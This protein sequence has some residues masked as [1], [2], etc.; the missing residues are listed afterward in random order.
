[1]RTHERPVSSLSTS[2]AAECREAMAKLLLLHLPQLLLL[3]LLLLSSL[4]LLLLLLLK[5]P[6]LLE[7]GY[8]AAVASTAPSALA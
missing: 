6:H 1:M 8:L 7:F 2:E 3:H 5:Q 4:L